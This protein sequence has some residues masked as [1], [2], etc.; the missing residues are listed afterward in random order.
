M[1]ENTARRFMASTF[2]GLGFAGLLIAWFVYGKIF[3]I[4]Y[5]LA[6]NLLYYPG[7]HYH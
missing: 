1:S 2:S 4:V 7:V 3:A 5:P 6:L